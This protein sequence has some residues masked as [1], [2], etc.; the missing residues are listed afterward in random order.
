MVTLVP[1]GPALGEN[2]ESVGWILKLLEEKAVPAGAVTLTR[3][4]FTPTGTVAEMLLLLITE[5]LAAAPFT[6]TA[7]APVKFLPLMVTLAE[8]A[9]VLGEKLVTEGGTKKLVGLV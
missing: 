6:F 3:P 7:V 8:G 5:K 2:P 9:P 1:A 4:L